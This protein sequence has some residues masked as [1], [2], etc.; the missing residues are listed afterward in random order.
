MKRERIIIWSLSLL[1]AVLLSLPWLVPGAGFVA[2]FAFLPLL[3]ADAL[4][5][6][7]GMRRFWLCY[8]GSF[9]VWNA[10]T[11]FW[12]CNATVGGGVFAILANSAQMALVWLIFRFSKRKLGGGALPYIFLAAMWIAWERRYFSVDISWPWLT[13]GN[14]FARSTALVQWYEYTGTIGGSLWV[15]LCN[16]TLFGMILSLGSGA[17]KKW[18]LK[19]KS[20]AVVALLAVFVLPLAVSLSIYARYAEKS[21]SQVDVLIAQPNFDPY[22][23]FES[24]SQA[25]QTS[26]LVSQIDSALGA[27][28]DTVLMLAPETFTGGVFMNDINSSPTVSGIQNM[29]CRYPGSAMLFGAST[30]DVYDQRSAPSILARQWGD[31]WIESHNSAIV[32]DASR[33]NEVYHKSKLV[34]GTELTP[35]PKIFVPLDNWLSGIMGVSGLMAR[36]VGQEEIS[37]LHFNDVPFGCAVCYESIYGEFCTGYVRKGARFMTVITNDAWWGNT[38]GYRQHCSYSSLRA[39]ELRRDIARCGNTGISCIIDQKGDVISQS[40]WWQ[41]ETLSGRLNLNS[42]Q[43]FFVR[44]GDIAGRVCTLVFLLMLMLLVARSFVPRR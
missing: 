14:A 40:S 42:E 33:R 5:D 29:L 7:A 20:S 13:L 44:N 19:A 17:W 25:E 31:R 41:R 37:L 23:K 3:F 11:T 15:W 18:N 36:E 21:E 1:S 28:S 26:V 8:L 27:Q 39:I 2:L 35:Y 22:Q 24:M 43:T 30:Y 12:V 32:T 16:L 34:V 38:P 9:I 10:A 6:E 4:A